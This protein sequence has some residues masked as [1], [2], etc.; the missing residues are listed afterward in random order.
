MRKRKSCYF[1]HHHHQKTIK[2]L[3][4]SMSVINVEKNSKENII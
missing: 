2:K 4:F 1:H 3:L